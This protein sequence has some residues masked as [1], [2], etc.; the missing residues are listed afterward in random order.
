MISIKNIEKRFNN[1]EVIKNFSLEIKPNTSYGLCGPNGSGKTTLLKII[2]NLMHYDSGNI[3]SENDVK[4]SYV[5]NNPRSFF[6]RLSGW[7]NLFY[8]G[9]LNGCTKE[10]VK[11]LVGSL[12]EDFN[13]DKVL[14]KPVNE[15]SIGQ[16]QVTSLIRSFL[17]EPQLLLLDEVLSNLDALNTQKTLKLFQDYKDYS[18]KF[19]HINC[20]HNESFLKKEYKNIIRLK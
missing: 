18:K 9:S 12:F 15:I 5:S 7:E 13:F 11:R 20:S 14:A 19:S 6:L 4:I 16:I 17:N 8:Y 2:A 1:K 3:S 10:D